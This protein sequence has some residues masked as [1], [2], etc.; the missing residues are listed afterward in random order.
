VRR[1]FAGAYTTEKVDR[2]TGWQFVCL[3]EEWTRGYLQENPGLHGMRATGRA[4]LADLALAQDTI[5][6]TTPATGRRRRGDGWCCETKRT[7]RSAG[8]NF[9]GRTG[10]TAR[11]G[12][13]PL[14]TSAR[15]AAYPARQYATAGGLMSYGVD[16]P[17]AYHQVG[18][19]A[20]RILKG[21]RPADLPVQQ[22]TKFEFVINLK[23]AKVL[24]IE[25]PPNLS[26]RADEVIE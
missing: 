19:Y 21:E 14:L 8:F 7:C 26:A 12:R 2:K 13:L 9:E 15:P 5:R 4:P 20:A 23:T 17:E 3:V 11:S 10:H 1:S 6:P 24:G 16:I 18:I 22:A 25:V